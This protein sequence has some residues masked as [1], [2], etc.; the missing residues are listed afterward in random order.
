MGMIGCVANHKGG[1]GKTTTTVNLSAALALKKKKILIIDND[2]Q[3]NATSSIIQKNI[4]IDK[5]LYEILDPSV[6]D[7]E[8]PDVKDCIYPTIHENLYILANVTETAA[9]EVPMTQRY[10]ESNF[11]LR[12]KVRDYVTAN[13]DFAFIDCPPTLSIFVNNAMYCADFLLI[14]TDAGSG[15]SL[16]GIKGILDLMDSARDDGINIKFLKILINKI[17]RRLSTHKAIVAYLH[18]KF[19]EDS[20]FKT[21]I[22]TSAHFVDAEFRSPCTIFTKEPRSKGASSFR[23]L[24]TEFLK[25]FGS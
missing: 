3:A 22:P 17:D 25:S 8:K 4:N 10:P 11:F 9:H 18:E 23:D 7:D 24:A 12:H 20:A 1:A 21:I 19:G 5:S 2:P 13:F 15:N 16:K 6:P 14:P